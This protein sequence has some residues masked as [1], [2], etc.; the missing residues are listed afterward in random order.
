MTGED[1]IA[2]CRIAMPVDFTHRPG[3]STNR[4][5]AVTESYLPAFEKFSVTARARWLGAQY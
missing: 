2:T 3:E 1:N 5:A 4:G